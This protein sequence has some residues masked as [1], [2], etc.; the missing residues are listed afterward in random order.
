VGSQDYNL[1]CLDASTGEVKWVYQTENHVDSSPA[2]VNDILY[3][4]SY[5]NRVYALTLYNS[6]TESL[7][8][9]LVNPLPWTTIIFDVI[10]CAR[11][12]QPK[13]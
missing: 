4:G 2:I 12:K 10:A 7:T 13:K 3:F 11:Q 6:T 8:Y 9:N 1:Y 5:D